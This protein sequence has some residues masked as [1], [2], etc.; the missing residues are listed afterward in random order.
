MPYQTMKLQ[1]KGQKPLQHWVSF[2]KSLLH[3]PWHIFLF[4]N[5][6]LSSEFNYPVVDLSCCPAWTLVI[7]D[8][9]I[10]VINS[11]AIFVIKFIYY[12]IYLSLHMVN[13]YKTS[14][15]QKKWQS[16]VFVFGNFCV[17][18]LIRSNINGNL[19]PF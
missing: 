12:Y 2:C 5:F 6:D 9:T 4:P 18:S 11:K 3:L 10:V 15:L 19:K 14:V 17:F 16:W 7:S 1:M 8:F 13:G